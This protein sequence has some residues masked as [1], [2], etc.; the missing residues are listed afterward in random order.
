M[1]FAR[2]SLCCTSETSISSVC[3]IFRGNSQRV[4]T[5]RSEECW[6][7]EKNGLTGN[8]IYNHAENSVFQE[9]VYNNTTSRY[10]TPFQKKKKRYLAT[11]QNSMKNWRWIETDSTWKYGL[12]K[13]IIYFIQ[14]KNWPW[15]IYIRRFNFVL[16]A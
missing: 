9:T 4:H 15:H 7:Q 11:V 12:E 13:V 2:S 1:W 16:S 8:V 14:S 10:Y 6:V 5:K 3:L